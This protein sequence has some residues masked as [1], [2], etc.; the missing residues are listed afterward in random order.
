[1]RMAIVTPYIESRGGACNLFIRL[2]KHFD[3]RIH[4]LRFDPGKSNEEFQ[5]LDIEVATPSFLRSIPVVQQ[6][7]RT[8]EN[9]SHFYNLKLDEYDVINAHGSP[10][11]FVRNRNPNVLWYCYTPF[12][13]AYDLYDWNFKRMPITKKPAAL[14]SVST[15]KFL[16]SRLVPKIECI[17]TVSNNT[18]SRIKKYLNRD[19][20]VLYPGVDAG[21]FR[22]ESYEQF[23]FYPSRI[24]PEKDFEYAIKA[25]RLFSSKVKGW[26]LVI[27]GS[28]FEPRGQEVYYRKIKALCDDSISIETDITDERMRELYARCYAVLFTPIDEDLG[29]I[30]LEGMASS[31][32]CIAKNEGGPRETIADGKDGFLVNSPEDMAQRMELLARNPDLCASLGEAGRAKV[33]KEFT[34]EAFLNRFEEKAREMAKNKPDS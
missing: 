17:F 28:I 11:E 16:E 26:K 27:A 12:R 30:P 24:V 33:V 15:F 34:W 6:T 4:C 23:F 8:I 22:C 1:M 19:S 7:M 29:L 3:A 20:E 9:A 32:P 5:N 18:R 13:F 2:A 25:F 14:A 10:S 21:D 31:K